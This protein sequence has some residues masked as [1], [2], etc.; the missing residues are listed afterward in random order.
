MWSCSN[1][2]SIPSFASKFVGFF[3]VTCISD[4]EKKR[5]EEDDTSFAK[6]KANCFIWKCCRL[7]GYWTRFYCKQE[8][9]FVY[10]DHFHWNKQTKVSFVFLS[11]FDIFLHFTKS[12]VIHTIK[13]TIWLFIRSVV[14]R[15]SYVHQLQTVM[16]G[17]LNTFRF[18][19]CCYCV[20]QYS[21]DR[22]L[23]GRLL[24]LLLL[25]TTIK[26]WL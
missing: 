11:F 18:H 26:R 10:S 9:H 20:V 16:C 12:T 7:A 8:F 23:L 14:L 4:M 5:M 13:L 3:V 25:L 1:S 17:V 6:Q 19:V 15:H 2:L 24:L 21:N 22:N